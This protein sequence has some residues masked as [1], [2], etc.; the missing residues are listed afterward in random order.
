MDS[1]N[2]KETT[3]PLPFST[4]ELWTLI[5]TTED[6]MLLLDGKGLVLAA[7]DSAAMIY[8]TTLRNLIGSS[9][10]DFIPGRLVRISRDRIA[11]VVETK[12]P[13]RFEIKLKDKYYD[14][15]VYPVMKDGGRADT[16]AV[17]IRDI[18]ERKEI[19]AVLQQTEEK[20][21]NI[22]E[23]ATE[24][25]FQVSAAGRFISANPS[26]ARIHGYNNPEELV[27][28]I[29]D[30]SHQLY[31]NPGHRF[32]L[33][34]ELNEKGRVENFEVQMYRKD[35]S[36]HW[37][38]INAR[39]VTDSSGKI[40]YHEG[41]M[42]D[43]TERKRAEEALAESE[44]RYRTLIE[45]SNDGIVIV[46]GDR[47]RYV[48]I[49]FVEM[50]GYETAEDVVGKSVL[51]VVHPDDLEKVT[52]IN[53][54]RQ[55]GEP[56][57]SR[58]E[59]KGITRRDNIIYIE[60]SATT[61]T[62]RGNSYYLIYLRDVTDRK[63]A[64]EALR[65]ERNRFH[66]LSENAP[67]GIA[68]IDVK[69]TF[70]YANPKFKELF[71]YGLAEVSTG[72]EWLRRAF[73]DDAYRKKVIL[74]WIDDVKNTKPGE[75]MPRTFSVM[76]KDG[77]EKAVNFIPVKLPSGEH[78]FSFE[79]ITERVKAQESF[80]KSHQELEKLNRA[81]TKAVNHISHELKTPLA[82]IQ[83][84]V[85]LLKNKLQCTAPEGNLQ[86]VMEVLERNL[87]RLFTISKETDEIFRVS[88][89]L[90]AGVLLDEFDR[91][92]D[93]ME[94]FSEMPQNIRVHWHA[95]KG[96]LG[97]Y[98]SGNAHSFQSID[99]YPFMF[100]IVEKAK[101]EADWRKIRFTVDGEHDLFVFLDP[102]ILKALTKS[103]L[104]NAIE[105]T[106][107]GGLI[108]ASIEQRGETV[109]LHITDHGIG[110]TEENQQY[111]FDG[112]FHTRETELYTSRR[113]YD[114]G[115][116]GKGLELMLVKA[117]AQRFGFEILMKSRR[118]VYI[119]SDQDICPGAIARCIHCSTTQNC[120]DS[121]G[122][123]FSVGFP[124]RQQHIF[125]G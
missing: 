86:G 91:L 118:C 119:P 101:E 30:I 27:A 84:N 47:N 66:S 77:A 102:S 10:F 29:T 6:I 123:T 20:Y 62:F 94:N 97:Q 19:E 15:H 53:T 121:G 23:N 50:F 72:K 56:V 11:E 70:T 14:N 26:L 39:V 31:V 79:D 59:F 93:R 88:Q 35:R 120:L 125:N 83:G 104:K 110:I 73:P 44:E 114:F 78:I 87:K 75:K 111:L 95:L 80:A 92:W 58:Y 96:W 1:E 42:Q 68:M 49:R 57:P 38:S 63:N 16:L 65:I 81:K 89:E 64:E 32:Q 41:T 17:Y 108:Q 82:V 67:F 74:T 12:R 61:I 85:R 103:L 115:A 45:H 25:I 7:N 8:D 51:L 99:L 36:L 116:G 100:Q 109:W 122:T 124:M 71:G 33:I 60:V 69:G 2:R 52:T 117:Y 98:L 3:S 43:I 105:N 4:E 48:N 22:Y 24:G 34:N 113:P 28:T 18:T 21:R 9:I 76:T 107:D 13:V 112:L 54:K 40:L 90:E 55:K 106:P 46:E 37:I 5:N